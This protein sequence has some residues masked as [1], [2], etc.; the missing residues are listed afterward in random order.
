MGMGFKGMKEIPAGITAPKGFFASGIYAGIKR[1]NKLDLAIIYSE[2]DA[3]V[4]GTFTR[5][6][7]KA[8]PVILTEKQIRNGRARAVIVNSGNANACTGSQGMKDANEMAELTAD[9]LFID[10]DLV[11]V[12]STGVIGELLP[13]SR[14]KSSVKL[15]ANSIS[16]DG[17][18]DAAIAIMTTDTFPKE[19]AVRGRVG[20]KTITVG[21]IAK[22]SGMIHP[23]MATMLAFISTDAAI[24]RGALKKILSKEVNQ[25]FNK[26]T[27]DGD[28]STNDM[29]LCMANGM[30]G[31]SPFDNKDLAQFQK[32][33]GHVCRSLALMI[34]KDGEGATKLVEILVRRAKSEKD[35]EKVGFA[36][37]NSSLVKTALF[38]GDP[39]W[40]RIMAAICY[41]GANIREERISISFDKV[42]MV[43]NGLGLGKE[44]ENKV[45]EVMKNKEYMITIDLNVGSSETSIWTTDL[46][47]D[48][49]KINVAY[50]S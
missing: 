36:V 38:A 25:S 50:R 9:A 26:I 18:R 48:Y 31:N 5:N 22:G 10:K 7:V 29:V 15:A 44:I 6:K 37:A 4:A 14:I 24:D 27:V 23:D 8:P 17:G 47:Y 13:M 16:P 42:K 12:S 34:T 39:N 46:S 41:S 32:M 21:G 49:V 33:I 19:V 28:T 20:G 35:A 30:A 11:C 2:R 1:T 43:K 40:G 3:T 45:A